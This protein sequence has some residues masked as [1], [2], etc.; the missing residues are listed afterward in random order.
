[1]RALDRKLVRDLWRLKAPL[2]AIALVMAAGVGSLVMAWS[3]SA[4]LHRS[5]NAYYDEGRFPDVF[6]Q[7]KRA[8]E[9]LSRRLAAIPGVSV[10]QTRV[11]HDVN[12]SIPGVREPGTARLV[13]IPDFGEPALNAVHLRRGRMPERGRV[14]EVVASEPFA[15]A[16][17]LGPGDT[18]G[19]VINGQWQ[20]LTI[21]GVGLS[22]EF[23]Y[24]VRAGEILP[25]NRRSGVLWMPRSELAEAL[26]M[27]GAFND[28]ALRLSKGSVAPEVIGQ[29]DTLL[30]RYGGFGAYDRTDHISDRYLRDEFDQLAVMG[31]LTP[32]IFLG[33]GA[34]LVNVVLGRLVRTQRE[35][36]AT[37]KAFGY[38]NASMA[39]HV[40]LMA[41]A[42][43][44][45]AGVVGA[46]IGWAL[47]AY[48]TTFYIE[49]FRFPLLSFALDP[50]AVA[51]GLAVAAAASV[52]GVLGALRWV[53]RLSPA[54]AMRPEAPAAFRPTI[55]ERLG[56]G[57]LPLRWRMA[58]RALENHPWRSALAALGIGMSAAVLVLSN[59]ALD[60]VDH[61]IDREYAASQRYDV[62][63]VFNEPVSDSG[64]HSVRGM[65]AG[66]A[67]L[68]A[69]PVRMAAAKI[70]HRQISRTVGIVGVDQGSRLSRLLDE[71]ERPVSVPPDGL[72]ISQNFADL[73]GIGA[74][75]S[76]HVQ[77]LE[78]RRASVLIPVAG[79]FSGYVGLTAYM[80]RDALNR[81][82]RDG[83]VMSGLFLRED[84]LRSDELYQRLKR[85][86]V[87]AAVT[88]KRE[89]IE[90]F[91]EVIAQNITRITV[92]HALFAAV[93]AFGVVYNNARIAFAERQR[94]LATLRVLGFTRA[95]VSRLLLGEITL[96]T[97]VGIPIGLVLGRGLAW[98]LVQAIETESYV[99]P[100]IISTRTYA[101]S[102]IVTACAAA[103]S[104][105]VVRRGVARLDL[106]STLKEA[107]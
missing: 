64:I 23:V 70:S 80:N 50:S 51:L 29:I 96:L 27:E 79:V 8:P 75:E 67:T 38:T 19:A 43:C 93:I 36:I 10:V 9:S 47:G 17:G 2:G 40:V 63:I 106:L 107:G 90:S 42:V 30:D 60:A 85:T 44:A 12:L 24:F 16:N 28:A 35:Q 104:A 81:T 62:S 87:V 100:L 73:L 86:P 74:G 25:D 88:S 13:S 101:F 61:M 37:L 99:F 59:F 26:N 3:T 94:E 103:C 14:A 56:M 72:L 33:V 71:R 21:V 97:L 92:L 57:G 31:T 58:L 98:W 82:M 95:E 20:T 55:V 69:E 53:V 48:L 89:L 49:V 52:L 68:Q 77:F 78:G 11:V 91:R 46:V 66:Q 76:L 84:S 22:P 45:A 54:E 5:R 32:A 1:M 105:W 18:L 6:V 65:L 102:A 41:L 15:A 34:F 7:L 39:R 83:R 4:S